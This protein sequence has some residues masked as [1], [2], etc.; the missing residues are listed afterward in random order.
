MSTERR[1]ESHWEKACKKALQTGFSG[2]DRIPHELIAA[3]AAVRMAAFQAASKGRSSK[4]LGGC[5]ALIAGDH[6]HHFPL[7]LWQ[8]GRGDLFDEALA[9]LAA[10]T[11][12][13]ADTLRGALPWEKAVPLSLS[14][15]LCRMLSKHLAVKWQILRLTLE[16]KASLAKGQLR[17]VFQSHGAALDQGWA[18]ICRAALPLYSLDIEEG[19]FASRFSRALSAQL[20]I[21][22]SLK[23]SSLPL[24]EQIAKLCHSLRLSAELILD[25]AG[26]V[27]LLQ[28]RGHIK[29]HLSDD[30]EAESHYARLSSLLAQ[31][32][33]DI[34]AAE[35]SLLTCEGRL[36]PAA[37]AA[38]VHAI[39]LLAECTLIFA[40]R[41]LMPLS[42]SNS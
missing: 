18:L 36:Q 21:E 8:C 1:G 32:S 28:R 33:G 23:R 37:G 7:S 29:G 4:L 27:R 19:P 3:L 26:Q 13:G 42:I 35:L 17:E 5:E 9:L 34:H 41:W 20:N 15:A 6:I 11:K 2:F 38:L 30:S 22:F 40:D 39:S 12:K 10:G 24:G 31:V 14:L 25:M 16:T